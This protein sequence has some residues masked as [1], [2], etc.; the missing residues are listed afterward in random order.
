MTLS[1]FNDQ[2][3]DRPDVSFGD[4]YAHTRQAPRIPGI[5]G[6]KQ[7]HASLFPPKAG[8]PRPAQFG[9]VPLSAPALSP[10]E[11]STKGGLS[12]SRS[13]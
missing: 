13:E 6:H 8:A 4:D 10:P 3:Y 2:I 5:A 7:N 9:A 12:C 1:I 11:A